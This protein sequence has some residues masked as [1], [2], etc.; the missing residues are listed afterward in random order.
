[1]NEITDDWWCLVMW[2]ALLSSATSNGFQL[3]VAGPQQKE[4]SDF[5]IV[6]I[7]VWRPSYP[8]D[9]KFNLSSKYILSLFVASI[10]NSYDE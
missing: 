5:Q 4:L 7:Q 1:M 2:P 3:V 10:R 9:Y 8:I 6:N